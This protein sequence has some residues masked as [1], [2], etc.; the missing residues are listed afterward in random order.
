ML[1]SSAWDD[2][3]PLAPET[4]ARGITSLQLDPFALT[5]PDDARK[6]ADQLVQLDYVVE[7]SDRVTAAVARVP[8]RYGTILRY[9]RG[10][11]DGSLGFERVATF[12]TE[13]SLLG[14][15]IDD[16][17]S[18]EAFRVYDHP[19]VRI[20]RRLNSGKLNAGTP[21]SER[22]EPPQGKA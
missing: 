19:E 22:R 2:A 3:L 9:Y 7:T 20:W 18:E 6:L 10:L 1:S 5:T 4:V 15:G 12:R 21:A 14:I 17:G 16:R 13:P 11:D 8:A